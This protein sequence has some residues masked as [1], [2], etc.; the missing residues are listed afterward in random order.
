MQMKKNLKLLSL[1]ALAMS[2]LA[3]TPAMADN[4]NYVP[5]DLLMAFRLTSGTGSDQT[6]VARLGDTAF[7]RDAT[8]NVLNIV[9]IGTLLDTTFGITAGNVAW[10]ENPNLSFGLAGVWSNATVGSTLQNGDPRQTIYTSRS[11]TSVGTEGIV[12]SA[13]FSAYSSTASNTASTGV[14]AFGNSFDNNTTLPAQTVATAIANTW[15]DFAPGGT[16]F[17]AFAG[18]VEQSFAP[19]SFGNFPTIGNTEG[20]LD[21]FRFQGVNNVAGQFNQGGALRTAEFQGT[22]VIDQSG[23]VSFNVVPEPSSALLLGMGSI[24][25]GFVR[26]R[27]VA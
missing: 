27:K 1:A 6:V 22:F 9:N 12:N 16:A 7:F 3:V 20:A 2:G 18:G 14:I 24:F 25:A 23:N 17:G 21:F 26:R 11:R 8:S 5:G 4:L 19:G 10:F 13:A 15:E